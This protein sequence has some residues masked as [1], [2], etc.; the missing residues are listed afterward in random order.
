MDEKRKAR[1][2]ALGINVQS[3]TP[4]LA[5][6]WGTLIS[7]GQRRGKSKP[8]TP[9]EEPNSTQSRSATKEDWEEFERNDVHLMRALRRNHPEKF[10]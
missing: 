1:Y 5:E 10:E 3:V 9:Q 2:K 8:S 6:K 4:E 7:P